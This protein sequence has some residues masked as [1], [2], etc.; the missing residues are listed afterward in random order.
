LARYPRTRALPGRAKGC[1]RADR[2]ARRVRV[3]VDRRG[4]V[5]HSARGHGRRP[6]GR[7]HRCGRQPGGRRGWRDGP[8]HPDPASRRAR[9]GDRWLPLGFRAP[10]GPR[11]SGSPARGHGVRAGEH[12]VALPRPVRRARRAQEDRLAMCGIAGIVYADPQRPLE[13]DLLE[14]MGSVM[15]HRGPDAGTF[16]ARPGIGLCSRRLRIIDVSGGDQPIYNEDRTKAVVLNGEIYNFLELRQELEA[17]GHHFRTRS[18]TEA[19]VH[20]YEEDG[21]RCVERL[22]GMFAFALWDETERRLVLARDRV[23]KKPLYYTEDLER[24]CFASELK[25]LLQDPAR[26]R[27]I[28]LEALDDYFSFGCVQGPATI[29]EGVAQLPPA[30]VLVWERGVV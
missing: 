27:A 2:G 17:R 14:R 1:S 12:G 4:N 9:D 6:S 25:A 16:H 26:K 15:A 8:G 3:A 21:V 5:Q 29:L 13:R 19:I 11:R 18:D 10:H 20:A 7:R 23:G 22:R 28:D 24:F 30:H